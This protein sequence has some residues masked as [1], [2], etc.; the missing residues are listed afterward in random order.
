P[1]NLLIQRRHNRSNLFPYTTLFRSAHYKYK[2]NY[3]VEDSKVDEWISQV[4]EMLE[5]NETQDATEFI[6]NFKFNLYA[7]EIY[8]FMPKGDLDRKSTRL[9]S[10][11]V[12]I[13]YAVS[14]LKE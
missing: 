5:N 14:C 9:N 6:D 1:I 12:K 7:K 13:S 10:S 3:Q 4:R 2:E 11:H 8:V